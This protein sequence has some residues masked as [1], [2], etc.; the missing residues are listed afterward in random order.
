[1]AKAITFDLDGV[2]G[3][4]LARFVYE[5]FEAPVEQLKELGVNCDRK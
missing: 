4:G 2:Y 3:I 5:G 1:M